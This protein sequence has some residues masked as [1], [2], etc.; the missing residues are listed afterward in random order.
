MTLYLS[1]SHVVAFFWQQS[2]ASGQNVFEVSLLTGM[3]TK[4]CQSV[5]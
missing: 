4:A 2:V 1:S 5:R 3:Y